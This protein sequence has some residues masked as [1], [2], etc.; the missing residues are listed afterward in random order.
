MGIANMQAG[1]PRQAGANA[2]AGT[3]IRS[4]VDADANGDTDVGTH[5]GIVVDAD[6]DAQANRRTRAVKQPQDES[7]PKLRTATAAQESHEDN[8]QAVPTHPDP[9]AAWGCQRPCCYVA[10][11]PGICPAWLLGIPL[12]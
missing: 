12:V 6:M 1:M 2:V 5:A 7:P 3:C 9:Q 10:P 11:S 8:A 4:I